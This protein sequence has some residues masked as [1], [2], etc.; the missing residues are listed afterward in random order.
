MFSFFVVVQ[1]V[2]PDTACKPRVNNH[3]QIVEADKSNVE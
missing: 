2:A 3:V 1:K